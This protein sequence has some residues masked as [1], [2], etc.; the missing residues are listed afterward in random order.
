MRK[1]TKVLLLFLLMGA[2]YMGHSQT[3]GASTVSSIESKAKQISK[4]DEDIAKLNRM[5]LESYSEEQ[6]RL[7]ELKDEL[8]A[9]LAEKAQ[10]MAEMRSGRFCNGCD[11]TASQ[12]KKAGVYDVEDHFASNGGT[13]S[14][15]PEELANKEAEY[16]RLIAAKEAEIKQFE[17]GENEFSRKRMEWGQQMDRLRDNAD[18]LRQEI[19]DLSKTFSEKVLDQ[20]KGMHKT[21]VGS[22]MALV[23][24]KHYREDQIDIL[25]VK[26]A[27]LANDEIKAKADYEDKLR[28]QIDEKI[29]D[30]DNKINNNIAKAA[31]LETA[32]FGRRDPLELELSGV[33]SRLFQVKTE[34]TGINLFEE[35]S[36]KLE[37]ERQDLEQKITSVENLLEEYKTTFDTQIVHLKQENTQFKDEIWNLKTTSFSQQLQ[38]GLE[39]LAKAFQVKR[40]ILNDAIA[41]NM[42]TL[43]DVGQ[44]LSLQK[45]VFR[46][47]NS[48][49]I[50]KV[51]AERIRL[52]TA[53]STAGAS[54][55]GTDAV[56]AVVSNWNKVSG[57]VGE[58]DGAHHSSDPVYG[59]EE[60][61]LIYFQHYNSKKS[62]MSDSDKEALSRN[63]VRTRYDMILNKITN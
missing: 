55:Y 8:A 9:L 63:T 17:E 3:A 37:K 34:L 54:C 39:N 28:R 19:T 53:C 13:H 10:S 44:Q 48:E 6:A 50:G 45:D 2:T 14:A 33:R 12:L 62:G 31:S 57:C 38:Q 7:Q 42:S 60:E 41:A 1:I 36:L 18:R 23:A 58:M 27:D 5:H 51:D 43:N 47:K 61:S 22:L 16:D 24:E 59:C 29:A 49:Y 40:N 15:T 30:Y 11:R 21:W 46:K 26:I 56:G 25:K 32:Y 35:D 4:Y 20:A 52:M